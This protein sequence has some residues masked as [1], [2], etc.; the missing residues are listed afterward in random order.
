MVTN[1]ALMASWI[2]SL[3]YRAMDFYLHQIS[4]IKWYDRRAK[5]RF[6]RTFHLVILVEVQKL[7]QFCLQSGISVLTSQPRDNLY[8]LYLTAATFNPSARSLTAWAFPGLR[9]NP[10][11]PRWGFSYPLPRHFPFSSLDWHQN[12]FRSMARLSW[13]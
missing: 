10:K 7:R 9:E 3:F 11:A 13:W 12:L 5:T 2:M 8:L 1:S 6:K 4:V